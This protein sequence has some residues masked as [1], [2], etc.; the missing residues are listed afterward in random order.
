MGAGMFRCG[1][2][3]PS[4][5][6]LQRKADD[7]AQFLKGR[8]W[9]EIPSGKYGGQYVCLLCPIDR[10]FVLGSFFKNLTSFKTHDHCYAGEERLEEAGWTPSNE[11]YAKYECTNCG[12]IHPG[13]PWAT[14]R[15]EPD[16][17]DLTKIERI[18]LD[19]KGGVGV[20]KMAE[21]HVNSHL[22]PCDGCGG[23]SQSP[24][25]E[26]GEPMPSAPAMP[27]AGSS[28]PGTPPIGGGTA[29]EDANPPRHNPK[30]SQAPPPDRNPNWTP[31]CGR[32]LA[33][34][35]YPTGMSFLVL[36]L[37]LI[38][39][40][41]YLLRRHLRKRRPVSNEGS[42]AFKKIASVL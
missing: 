2:G 5:E 12:K 32:R 9:Y 19:F 33:G 6:E 4:K 18:T 24:S 26:K 27:P 8:G 25:P 21:L 38:P 3:E 20:Q 16:A 10:Q 1:G 11:H 28:P 39:L 22:M 37:G 34:T 14:D 40:A 35:C 13:M 15:A 30:W 7:R 42:D 23:P 36:G 29:G 31:G 41:G 17:D